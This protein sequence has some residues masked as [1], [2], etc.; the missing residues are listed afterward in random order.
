MDL[1][2]DPIARTAVGERGVSWL[3][4]RQSPR[5]RASAKFPDTVERATGVR[6]QLPAKCAD[7]FQR[8]EKFDSLPA[9]AEAVKQYIRERSRAWT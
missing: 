4:A 7:L 9:D 8:S 5:H 2:A 3:A 6:P 1:P